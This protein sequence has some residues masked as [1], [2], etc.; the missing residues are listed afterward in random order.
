MKS[1]N[2]PG[3]GISGKITSKSARTQ[4]TSINA[5]KATFT[6]FS[7]FFNV[8]H[9]YK[10]ISANRTVTPNIP[11]TFIVPYLFYVFDLPNR[12]FRFLPSFLEKQLLLGKFHSIRLS[13]VSIFVDIFSEIH[14]Q[15]RKYQHLAFPVLLRKL[16][17]LFLQFH[18]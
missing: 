16:A 9:W 15:S 6:F 4:L 3:P 5:K 17:V 18:H 8:G 7:F 14:Q 13:F 10:K 12:F 11:P 2:C 1:I